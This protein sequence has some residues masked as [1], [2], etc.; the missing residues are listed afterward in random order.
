MIERTLVI[1]KPDAVRRKLCGKVIGT[2]EDADLDILAA[3][4]FTPS[5]QLLDKHYSN[6]P[7]YVESLGHKALNSAKDQGADIKQGFGTDN[8]LEIGVAVRKRLLDYMSGP[9]M[10]MV[11]QGNDAI[12]IVRKLC[13]TTNP[14]D[15]DPSTIRGKFCNDSLNFSAFEKRA[16]RNLMHASGNAEEAAAEIELWFGKI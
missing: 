14:A 9:V 6:N 4:L 3:K 2:F 12:R 7:A 10:A 13:G 16:V 15:A 11:L 8:A 5:S 1:L